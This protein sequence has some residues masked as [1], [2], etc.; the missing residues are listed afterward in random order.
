MKKNNVVAL[1]DCNNFYVSCERVFD[2]K[3]K[4]APVAV[5]SNNDGVIIARSNEVKALG[6]KMGAPV[7]KCRDVLNRHNV[8][9]FSSNFVLYG[10]MSKRVMQTLSQFS[11][12]IEIYSI[13]EAFLSFNSMKNINFKNY[14]H[15]IKNTVKKWTGIPVSIGIAQTK[16]LAKVANELTK[17]NGEFNGVLDFT[18]L[19][20]QQID[21]Y[22]ERLPVEDLWGVGRKFA[23]LLKAQGILNAKEMKYASDRWVK[24]RMTIQGLR[25]VL[26]LRGIECIGLEI[27]SKPQK[28]VSTTRS[29]GRPVQ[30]FAILKKAV[31]TFA[32]RASQK[33]REQGQKTSSLQV[34]IQTDRFKKGDKS[35]FNS[36]CSKLQNPSSDACE[37][38]KLSI[39]LLKK[40]YKKDFLYKKAGVILTDLVEADNIQLD[41]FTPY[42]Q[43]G[44][45]NRLM[46][47]MD[48]IN[49]R[50][51]RDKCTVASAGIK[52]SS[53]DM[54]QLKKS[55]RFTTAWHEI[56]V[57]KL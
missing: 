21:N 53:W 44:K 15:E 43:T 36:A 3:L 52:K 2:P 28:S 31:S 32:V 11:S 18:C 6:I 30:S 24:K 39:N 14:A 50:F 42:E 33:L 48:N 37:I 20:E 41:I 55:K 7:F 51:G 40:I 9:V 26:E 34:F 57:A 35:Y 19:S 27:S 10:D 46:K 1:V 49:M 5:L 47:A 29:F 8:K 38:V 13:D 25:M 45:S 17:K 22:L 23:P 56:I 54:R 12:E 16:T 4:G